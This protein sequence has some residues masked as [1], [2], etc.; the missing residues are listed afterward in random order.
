MNAILTIFVLAVPAYVVIR[1]WIEYYNSTGT[2]WER[3]KQAFSNSRTIAWTQLNALSVA[4]VGGVGW[5]S[6]A[7]GAPGVKEAIQPYLGPEYMTAY[8][9]FVLIGAEFARRRTLT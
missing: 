5:L 2:T 4:A 9:L 7:A 3:I 8:I 1:I 6:T